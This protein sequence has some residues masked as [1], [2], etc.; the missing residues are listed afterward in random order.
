MD[1]LKRSL[2]PI[3][4]A[5]WKEIDELSRAL[6]RNKLTA[7]RLVDVDG[8]HGIDYAVVPTG[9]L[10]KPKT[11]KKG[12]VNYGV[13]AVQ[14]LVEARVEFDL[15]IWELDDVE[16]GAKDPDLDPLEEAAAKIAAF[17]EKAVYHGFAAGNI[18]GLIASAAAKPIAFKRG[19]AGTLLAALNQ[20]KAGL[21]EAGIAGPYVLTVNPEVWGGFVQSAT[22]YPFGEHVRRVVDKIVF[23]PSIDAAL[24]S[25]ARGGDFE[26]VLGQDLAIG[27][28]AHTSKT[29]SLYF[30][31]SFTFRVLEPRALVP[32]TPRK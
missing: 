32:L 13:H 27:Y 16:R 31:E 1:I 10:E 12:E 9:R 5:A 17:E 2:A 15:D 7:R 28:H 8:P 20:A 29:V 14:P 23:S 30:T 11:A 25:S 6:L 24:V 3:T 18:P 22:G 19:D 21:I 4:D 26:L